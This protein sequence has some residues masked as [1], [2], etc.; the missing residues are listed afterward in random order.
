MRNESLIAFITDYIAGR[1]QTK[2]EAFEKEAAKRLTADGTQAE[3]IVQERQALILR[4]T[5]Q[6]WLTNAASR[7]GQIRLVTHV[8]KFT[9]ADSKSS[10]I[11]SETS[12]TEGY[13]SSAA[14]DHLI[15][16]AMGNAAALDVARLLQTEVE[17]DSLFACLKRKDYHVLAAFAE[18][19]QQLT[20][21]I[22]GFSQ[23][24]TPARLT[25]HKLAKQIYFPVAEG[26]HLL[27]PLFASSL[28]HVIHQKMMALRFSEESKAIRQAHRN[29]TWHRKPLVQFPNTAEM[30][31]G[32]TKPQNISAL[33]SSRGGCIWLLSA[34]P[35]VWRRAEKPPVGLTS[36][37]RIGGEFDALVRAPLKRMVNLFVR[38][39]SYN[40]QSIRDA[41]ERYI[42]EIID[43]LF[44]WSSKFQRPEWQGWTREYPALKFHQQLWL[45]PWRGKEDET[46]RMQREQGDWQEQVAEDFARWLNYR[47]GKS[48]PD[49]GLTEQNEWKTWP[50]FRRQLREMEHIIREGL[51]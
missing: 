20:Q 39:R 42:D 29:R 50:H 23:T 22:E 33:N 18:N 32:G 26:Y 9:H 15:S 51:R 17:G 45:D 34:Q 44:F 40:N 30:H 6:N 49:V 36:V 25:S 43:T 31:F 1:R 7:A 27:S 37:F 10:S 3:I 24:L 19:E 2:L 4:Y 5:P 28:A 48:L 13:L 16:D 14:V 38:S 21:W 11:D 46:F 12:Q 41:S 47:L 8:A 35:P